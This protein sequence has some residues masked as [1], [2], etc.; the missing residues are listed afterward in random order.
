MSDPTDPLAEVDLGEAVFDAD[1]NQLGTIR[2]ISE[3]GIFVT[4]RTGVAGMSIEHERAGHELGEAELTWRCLEC[5]AVGDLDGDL[6][7]GCPDCGA[8]KEALYYWTED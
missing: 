6:P 7:D 2:G 3:D 4:T 8:P 1:G 5:G